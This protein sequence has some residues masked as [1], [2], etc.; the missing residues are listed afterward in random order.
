[1]SADNSLLNRG[2]E[3]FCQVEDTRSLK[4]VAVADELVE[5]H[6][7]VGQRTEFGTDDSDRFSLHENDDL[8]SYTD[9]LAAVDQLDVN[10]ETDYERPHNK[11]DDSS[12]SIDGAIQASASQLCSIKSTS[13]ASAIIGVKQDNPAHTRTQVKSNL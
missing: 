13:W 4:K 7:L 9:P 6:E 8:V 2:L 3:R 1:M 11:A 5:K 10:A 12:T